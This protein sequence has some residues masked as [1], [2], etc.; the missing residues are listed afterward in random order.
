MTNLDNFEV[1]DLPNAEFI[2]FGGQM[3]NE[4][5][6]DSFQNYL[7]SAFKNYL[8]TLL[9]LWTHKNFSRNWNGLL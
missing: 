2:L 4:Q 5:G 1:L 8:P 9:I 7:G 3:E 6:Y